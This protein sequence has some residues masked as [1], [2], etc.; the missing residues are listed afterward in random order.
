M[1]A[2]HVAFGDLQIREYPLI[3]GDNPAC[4]DGCPISIGWKPQATYERNLDFYEYS[5]NSKR[6]G[7]CRK[8][9]VQKRAQLLL[10]SGYS[11]EEIAMAVMLVDEAKKARSESLKAMGGFGERTKMLLESTGRLPKDLLTG[12]AGL[13]TVK[14]Q[15]SSKS[16]T[17]RSA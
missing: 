1:S 3:L 9:S 7:K 10:G 13:L 15:S 2:K 12:M 16:I 8:V 5:K 6:K 4:S 14:P 11:L 17:A